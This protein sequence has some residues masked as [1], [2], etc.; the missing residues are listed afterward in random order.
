VYLHYNFDLCIYSRREGFSTAATVVARTV[1]AYG[2]PGGGGGGARRRPRAPSGR[3]ES[4]ESLG[5]TPIP[6]EEQEESSS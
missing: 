6:M 5:T 2:R 4:V 1:G 3:R